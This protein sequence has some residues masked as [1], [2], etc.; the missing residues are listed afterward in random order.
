VN[1]YVASSWRNLIYRDVVERLRRDGDEVYDFKDPRNIFSWKDIDPD[2]QCWSP[3]RFREAL[4]SELAERGFA[5][6]MEA[7]RRADFVV[8]VLPAGASAHAEAGWAAGAGKP[9]VVYV[10]EGP[11]EALYDV[12]ATTH[13][14][15]RRAPW[16]PELMYKMFAVR[17]TIDE[18]AAVAAVHRRKEPV[19]VFGTCDMPSCAAPATRACRCDGCR[20]RMTSPY[21]ACAAHVDGV[22]REHEQKLESAPT[23]MGLL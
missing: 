3:A 18:V 23:W 21:R 12:A 13:A 15:A 5:S 17:T 16:E 7:L 1:V 11:L 19:S 8:L 2:W 9:V 14:V 20:R 4:G 10:P 6:D 22:A